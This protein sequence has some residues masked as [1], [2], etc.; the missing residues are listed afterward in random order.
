MKKHL[1][2]IVGACFGL[3]AGFTLCY[4]CLVLPHR[5]GKA[6]ATAWQQIRQ[7]EKVATITIARDGSLSLAGERI[8]LSQLATRLKE[9]SAQHPVCCVRVDS[10]A[11]VSR[12][13]EVTDACKGAGVSRFIF[14]RATAQ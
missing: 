11:N 2:A 5:E 4:I 10:G 9:V 1:S 13:N 7:K 3:C 12:F 6:T 8:D 14:A